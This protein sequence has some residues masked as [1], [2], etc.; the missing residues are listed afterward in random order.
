MHMKIRFI[1]SVLVMSAMSLSHAEAV[2]RDTTIRDDVSRY[3]GKWP[4]G[5]GMLY[6][7][8]KGLVIGNFVNG[9]PSGECLCHLPNGE[10]YWG[11]FTDG[12]ITGY[13]RIFRRSSDIVL[14]GSFRKGRP[15]GRDTLYRSDG[16]VLVA[17]FDKGRLRT[18][19]AEYKNPSEE[20]AAKKPVYPA[21][22]M[23]AE[24]QNFLYD[25]RVHWDSQHLKRL[26][27]LV[28][29]KF[30]GGDVN[31]FSRWIKSQLDYPEAEEGNTASN[32][33]VIEFYVMKDG[34]VR[35]ATPMY[36]EDTELAQAVVDVVN[37]SPKWKP[38]TYKGKPRNMKMA[39][40]VIFGLE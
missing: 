27:K 2:Q 6:S 37:S 23:N 30:Q 33:L 25:L 20:L 21:M 13:G 34:T 24:Q 28:K 12:E 9:V 1:L 38:G 3:T 22:K 8:E 17:E 7:F 10:Q 5:Q 16:S 18:K 31:K 26:K 14:T 19:I 36:G 32:S 4:E 40:P 39:V 11:E 35:N 15:H 29:P